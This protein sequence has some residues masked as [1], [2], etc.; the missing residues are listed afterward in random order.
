VVV[1]RFFEQLKTRWPQYQVDIDSETDQPSPGEFRQVTEL[2]RDRGEFYVVRDAAMDR[3]SDDH[4]YALMSDGEGPFLL[5]YDRLQ[6][7]DFRLEDVIEPASPPGEIGAPDPYSAR[8]CCPHIWQFTLV[9][10][11][12][13]S[14]HSFSNWLYRLLCN[15]CLANDIRRSSN[16]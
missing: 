13:P 3:F 9:T 8:L 11:D 4:A 12:E 14:Q 15:Q 6:N 10:P 2:P 16:G 7:V 1:V 5:V